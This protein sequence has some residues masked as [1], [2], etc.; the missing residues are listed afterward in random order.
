MVLDFLGSTILISSLD[1]DY[2]E[3]DFY[4]N[5]LDFLGYTI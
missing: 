4:F 3:D 2:E 1:D 5:I